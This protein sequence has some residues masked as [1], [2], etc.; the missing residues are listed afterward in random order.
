[1]VVA[2]KLTVA[3]AANL[4]AA[5]GIIVDAP[6]DPTTVT[7]HANGDVAINS[8][9]TATRL[10]AI[11]AGQ[12][13]SGNMTVSGPGSLTATDVDSDIT[14]AAGSATGNIILT[15]GVVAGAEVRLTAAA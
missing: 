5:G 8:A 7:L 1:M 4:T 9:V 3:E 13:G 15:G 12:D 11:F 6:I 10:I 2:G 14:I